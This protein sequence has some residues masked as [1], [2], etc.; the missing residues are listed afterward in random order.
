SFHSPSSHL[1][2]DLRLLLFLLFFSLIRRPPR[3]TLFP[4]TTLFR[5]NILIGQFTTL[6]GVTPGVWE[7]TADGDLV[8]IYTGVSGNRGVYEL[9]NGNILTT[10]ANGVH[11]IDRGS[12]LVETKISGVGARFITYLQ[13]TP[14]PCDAPEDLSW[15][16]VSPAG[17]STA[18][19]ASSEVTVTFDASG[20]APGEYEA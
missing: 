8:G 7:L 15:L 4:Y 3:S 16:T 19:G 18:P 10:N 11:E 12:T 20:L 14:P 6:G 1:S 2:S 5:S 17:G 13:V 9:P